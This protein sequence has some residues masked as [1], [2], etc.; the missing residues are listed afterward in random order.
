[1]PEAPVLDQAA[2]DGLL[3]QVDGDFAFIVELIETFLED[4]PALVRE[5]C[6]AAERSELEPL[7]RAAH[8]LKSTAASLGAARLSQAAASAE[9]LAIAG[10][11]PGAA[12]L[13][14]ALEAECA[15]ASRAL[16]ELRNQREKI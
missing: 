7:R 10:D 12:A 5:A 11:L 14:P 3:A 1:V 13:A 9:R 16:A 2:I 15:D 6:E 4:A 8:T